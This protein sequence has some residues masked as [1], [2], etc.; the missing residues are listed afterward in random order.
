MPDYS[1]KIK[2]TKNCLI[3]GVTPFPFFKRQFDAGHI[4]VTRTKIEI[5]N[6]QTKLMQD[7]RAGRV[8]INNPKTRSVLKSG[9][10]VLIASLGLTL[11]LSDE[12]FAEAAE[13]DLLE[14]VENKKT[15]LDYLRAQHY[16]GETGFW[17]WLGWAADMFNPGEDLVF[18]Q[19]LLFEL[20]DINIMAERLEY[21]EFYEDMLQIRRIEDAFKFEMGRFQF[22]FQEDP[23]M[24]Q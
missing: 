14:L 8:T 19:D 21:G 20:A 23:F 11:I 6:M 9:N 5:N 7:L 15:Y 12:A 16:T 17:G 22:Q 13:E 2:K 4:D 3:V 24:A 10:G 18:A 1:R